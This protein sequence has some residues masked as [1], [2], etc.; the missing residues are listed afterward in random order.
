M[1]I[2]HYTTYDKRKLVCASRQYTMK[3]IPIIIASPEHADNN[4]SRK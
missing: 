1:I 2:V 4:V 3:L